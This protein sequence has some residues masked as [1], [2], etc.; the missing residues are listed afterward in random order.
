MRGLRPKERRKRCD[1]EHSPFFPFLTQHA[2]HPPKES[3]LRVD[4]EDRFSSSSLLP[5]SSLKR[6]N[7]DQQLRRIKKAAELAQEKIDYTIAHNEHI[8]HAIDVVEAFLRKKHRICYG[9]QAINAHLPDKYKFYNPEYTIPDYDFYTPT[10]EQDI[11]I[12][13]QDLKKAGF[14]EISA[15]EGMHEG[16][17]KLYVDYVPVAD[18]TA[19]D[20]PLY[21]ILSKRELRINGISYM[22]IH[23]LRMMMYLELSRPRGEVERWPKVYERL[24][25]LN[26]FSSTPSCRT[27]RPTTPSPALLS[28]QQVEHTLQWLVHKQRVFAG[29][30]LVHA[31]QQSLQRRTK[32]MEWLV[33]TRKPILFFSPTPEEDMRSLKEELERLSRLGQYR[34]KTQR[35]KGGGELLPVLTILYQGKLPVLYAIHQTACHSYFQLPLSSSSFRRYPKKPSDSLSLRIASVDTLV[36]LYFSLS[37]LNDK[38]LTMGSMECLANQLIQ[39]SIRMRT[40]PEKSPF[41]FI[42]LNCAGHQTTMPS[43]I[44]AKVRRMTERKSRIKQMMDP[45][46][47]LPLKKQPSSLSRRKTVRNKH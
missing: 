7:I 15:R 31:Y 45:D 20:A 4:M 35:K 34:I 30:D 46:A 33:R 17:I 26:M 47:P 24:M 5:T 42:S 36:T 23:T 10:P 16:T 8:L 1:A 28:T 19:I 6:K 37:L 11:R 40:Q 43:L 25:L 13:V 3:P 14:Q 21:H 29:L 41:P 18:I 9:G 39:L 12:L 22:D 38:F 32:R 2:L 27:S 44:R